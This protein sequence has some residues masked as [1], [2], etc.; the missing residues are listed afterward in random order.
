VFGVAGFGE[1]GRKG[2]VVGL[3]AT[4]KKK[5]HDERFT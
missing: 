2:T 3:T 4:G 1:A 5:E